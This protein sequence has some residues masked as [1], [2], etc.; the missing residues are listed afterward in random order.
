MG[1]PTAL[2]FSEEEKLAKQYLPTLRARRAEECKKNGSRPLSE[3][4]SIV[5]TPAATAKVK[6]YL[7]SEPL[8]HFEAGLEKGILIK[9]DED[10]TRTHGRFLGKVFHPLAVSVMDQ[11]RSDRR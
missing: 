2:Q 8:P 9:I 10:G 11:A 6:S 7:A 1:T 3:C 4:L 5:G